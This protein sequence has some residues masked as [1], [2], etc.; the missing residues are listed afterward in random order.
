MIVFC[1]VLGGYD[2]YSKSKRIPRYLFLTEAKPASASEL[3]ARAERKRRQRQAQEEFRL[4]HLMK[5][6]ETDNQDIDV[7]SCIDTLLMAI[8]SQVIMTEDSGNTVDGKRR[9]P[10]PDAGNIKRRNINSESNINKK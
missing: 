10:T 8:P 6:K 5:Q 3:E 9:S 1:G 2:M 7:N 4:K